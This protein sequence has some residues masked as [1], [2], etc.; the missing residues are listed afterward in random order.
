MQRMK[1]YDGDWKLQDLNESAVYEQEFKY[2]GKQ[3]VN[4]SRFTV[5]GSSNRSQ[6]MKFDSLNSI[7]ASARSH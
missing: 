4:I 1:M 6:I 7:F 3:L 5:V 2:I